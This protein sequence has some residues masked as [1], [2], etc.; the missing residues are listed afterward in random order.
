M[1]KSLHDI[2]V[3]ALQLVPEHAAKHCAWLHGAGYNGLK[4]LA[5]ALDD[6]KK[7]LKPELDLMGLDLQ[8]VSCVFISPEIEKLRA[9]QSR[10]FL[11]QCA[12]WAL[13]SAQ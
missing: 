2:E 1:K 9:T 6:E 12:P 4:Y 13:S 8:S 10:I 5:E 7:T 11:A 3:L